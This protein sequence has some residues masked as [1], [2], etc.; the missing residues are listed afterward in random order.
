M[1]GVLLETLA[2]QRDELCRRIRVLGAHRALPQAWYLDPAEV[3]C[4]ATALR[5]GRGMPS[6]TCAQQCSGMEPSLHGA[7]AARCDGTSCGDPVTRDCC[8][9]SACD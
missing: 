2:E 8:A 6:I 9:T 3:R 7:Q 5:A 1:A 4:W